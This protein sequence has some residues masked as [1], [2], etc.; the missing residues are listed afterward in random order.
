MMQLCLF[1]F[2]G[3][4]YQQL[5]VAVESHFPIARKSNA[6]IEATPES[7]MEAS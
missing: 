6:K 2:L 7:L 1:C 3:T 5:A 4:P